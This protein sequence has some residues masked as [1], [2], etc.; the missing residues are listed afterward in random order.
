M[1]KQNK[2]KLY[3]QSGGDCWRVA[4]C[5]Y[6][7]LPPKDIPHFVKLY[8]DNFIMETIKWLNKRGKS[9]VYIPFENFL[10]TGLKYNVNLAPQGKCIVY[11]TADDEGELAHACFV[12]NGILLEVA[13]CEYKTILGYFVIYDL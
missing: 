4:L 10:E 6:L 13:S 12:N 2:I 3:K 8:G 5:N 9:M 1:K 11:V 7:Q